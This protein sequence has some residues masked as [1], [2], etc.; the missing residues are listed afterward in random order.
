MLLDMIHFIKNTVKSALI[1]A[2]ITVFAGFPPARAEDPDA[3]LHA[4]LPYTYPFDTPDW[5]QKL[6]AVPMVIEMF[7]SLDCLFCPRAEHLMSDFAQKTK[8]ILLTCHTDPEGDDY[9]LSRGFC[10]DRQERYS[11]ALTDGLL[12]TPQLVINGHIDAVGHEFDD[13]TAGLKSAL[14]DTVLRLT[15]RAGSE[16]GIYLI[17]LPAT[18]MKDSADI[19]LITY[20]PPYTVPKTMRQSQTRPDPLIRVISH[21][22]PLG[23]WNGRAKTVS[24]SF[25]SSD[26]AAGFVVL[27]QKTDGTIVAASDFAPSSAA[28]A[29]AP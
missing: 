21:L 25:T 11:A 10:L 15:P 2:I 24:L 27:I 16:D 3:P 4:T 23:V 14:N 13:V 5:A 26:D 28:P 12:Y 6:N 20:R 9:P 7:T 18:Q 8:I 29:P 22:T 19:I 17:D 1:L